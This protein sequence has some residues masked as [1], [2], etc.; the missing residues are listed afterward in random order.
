M[1]PKMFHI[2]ARAILLAAVALAFLAASAIAQVD[3]SKP[4][5]VKTKKAPKPKREHFKGDVLNATSAAITVRSQSDMR[6]IRTFSY[7]PDVATRI[8]KI[9]D[10]GGYQYGDKVTIET[11]T[12]S[13][14]ALQIKGKPSK[15][16]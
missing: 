13:N 8:Q 3:T 9:I 15:P 6:T 2:R 11:D 7:S 16:I 5:V 4:I 1:V 12:G 14:V 10:K